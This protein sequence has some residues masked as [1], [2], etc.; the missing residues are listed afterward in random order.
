MIYKLVVNDSDSV[1][2]LGMTLD[3][4]LNL[5]ETC[6]EKTW[7]I[8]YLTEKKELEESQNYQYIIN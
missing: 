8:E 3:G 4:K 7:T 6:E 2:Y 1:K 5:E